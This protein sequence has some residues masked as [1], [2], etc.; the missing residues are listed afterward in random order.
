[1]VGW[2]DPESP[3]RE[4]PSCL[5]ARFNAFHCERGPCNATLIW[6]PPMMESRTAFRLQSYRALLLDARVS[7]C[8]TFLFSPWPVCTMPGPLH[9]RSRSSRIYE[10]TVPAP[11]L[12]ARWPPSGWP[13]VFLSRPRDVAFRGGPLFT[14]HSTSSTFSFHPLGIAEPQPPRP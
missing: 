12:C 1:M 4:F 10:L 7:V 3:D 13:R 9:S 8:V 11:L 6:C 2:T 5:W 14:A